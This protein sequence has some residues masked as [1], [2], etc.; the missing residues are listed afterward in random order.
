MTV[1]RQLAVQ[2]G[3]GPMPRAPRVRPSLVRL[4]QALAFDKILSGNRDISCMTCHLPAFATGDGRSLAIG[5]GGTGLG[6]EPSASDRG[7][8]PAERASASSTSPR[9]S[10]SSG[11]AGSSR[12]RTGTFDTPAGNASRPQMARVFEFGPASALGLFP[13]LSRTEM[14]GAERQRAG[15][16]RRTTIT[17]DGLARPDGPPGRIPEYRRL[18]EAAYPGTPFAEMTFAH[19]SNAI[20]G[21]LVDRVHLQ[22]YTPWDRFLAGDDRAL[23]DGSA[24]GGPDLPFDQVLASATTGRRSRDNQFHNVAVAQFGP[25]KGDWAERP[26]R[27]RADAST[28]LATDRY[29]FRTTPLRN[30]ELTG[31][32]GHDGAFAQLHDFIAHYSES[33]LK[34]EGFDPTRLEP[35]LRGTL[36]PTAGAILATRDTIINGVVLPPETVDQLTTFMSALTDPRARYLDRV[37]PWTVPS[38]LPVDR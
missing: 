6:P 19:A 7:L 36:Q 27:L 38:G 24:R 12:P 32:Y 31:P 13:V 20:A 4:G 29:P 10:R 23:S 26:R 35:L 9:C 1:V 33:D 8:H 28:G 15:G 2:R 14:R 25:G 16:H 5:Q 34:L 21:F 30:V 22:R 3:I 11:T 18:F 17:P 37:V